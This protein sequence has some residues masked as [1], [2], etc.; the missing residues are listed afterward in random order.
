LASREYNQKYL[1]DNLTM[2]GGTNSKKETSDIGASAEHFVI[3]ELLRKR[4]PVGG[5]YNQNSK[6]DLFVKAGSWKTVQVKVGRVNH[7]TGSIYL[8]ACKKHIVSDLIAVVDLLGRR[9]KW[10]SNTEEPVP[11]ELL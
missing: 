1:N 2:S 11:E 8:Q 7:K 4:L 3:S 9:I 5:P 6:H 10:M